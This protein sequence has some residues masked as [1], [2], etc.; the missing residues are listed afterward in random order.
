M[1]GSKMKS[2]KH[3]G[4]GGAG[5]A[6]RAGLLLIAMVL[7]LAAR[8]PE[9]RSQ[10]FAPT[11]PM[12]WNSWDCFGAS[13]TEAEV[14]ANAQYLARELR[15]H[16]WEYV[17]VDVRWYAED[18]GEDHYNERDPGNT[19]DQWGRLTPAVNRFPSAAGGR[20]FGPLAERVHGLGLKF[21]IH[22]M[23]GVPVAAVRANTPVMGAAARA[24]EIYSADGQCPWLADMYPVVADRPGA[25]E[26]YDSIFALYASWGVDYV[27]VDDLTSPYH[28]RELELI[29]SAIDRA[30]RPMVL[31]ASPGPTPL[32]RADHVAAHANLWR[33]SNDF[34]DDW[35]ALR[36]QFK[37]LRAWAPHGRPGA[38]PDADML[39]LG[40]FVRPHHGGPRGT[41]FTRDEQVTMLSLWCIVRSPL[42]LG[43]DLPQTDDVTRALLINDEALAVNQRGADP[44]ELFHRVAQAAWV[45]DAP[46]SA[47]LNLAL[48]N[49]GTA[50]GRVK[51]TFAE[52]GR[53]GP[54]SARDLWSRRDLGPSER[55]FTVELPPHG[56]GLY[57]LSCP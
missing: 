45:S 30:G 28:A 3:F 57:R 52:L 42:M 48:F 37:R 5:L 22:V 18:P 2:M 38:W 43:G 50:A 47:G 16:G 14:L 53:R 44:R 13:V 49:L 19:M 25:Q 1:D 8:G 15:P 32:A 35:S 23:R 54:C 11:P 27:K 39:P 56:A 36:R 6:M 46:A 12:G 55:E 24:S 21:G 40:N 7:I 51:V 41:S 4:V 10:D 20:G 29:R 9:P 34:W 17:V 31:S 33:I 26:Y